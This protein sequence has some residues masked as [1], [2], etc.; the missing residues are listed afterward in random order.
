M[1]VFVRGQ[2][3]QQPGVVL[4]S[5]ARGEQAQFEIAGGL[6][7]EDLLLRR[8]HSSFSLLVHAGTSNPACSRNGRS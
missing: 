7:P 6:R 2:A 8:E 3:Q 1:E 5:P 4:V